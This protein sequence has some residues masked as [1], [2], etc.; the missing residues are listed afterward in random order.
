MVKAVVSGHLQP[1]FVEPASYGNRN[2]LLSSFFEFY[3]L[4]V[5]K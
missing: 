5:R 1:A 2:G 4:L 3:D